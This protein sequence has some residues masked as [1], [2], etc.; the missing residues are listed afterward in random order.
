MR[1]KGSTTDKNCWKLNVLNQN[2]IIFSGEYK[3]LKEIANECGFTYNQVVE[4]SSGRK[5]QKLGRFDTKYEL[6]KMSGKLNKEE[7]E[8]KEQTESEEETD[9]NSDKSL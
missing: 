8:P 1:R 6:I 7:E 9:L 5:K 4:I 3:T 2:E